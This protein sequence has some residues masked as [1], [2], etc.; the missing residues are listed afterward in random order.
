MIIKN[1]N[2]KIKEKALNIPTATLVWLI[3]LIGIYVIMQIVSDQKRLDFLFN[4]SFIPNIYSNFSSPKFYHFYSP[5]TYILIHG[6]LTHLIVNISMLAAFGS[7]IEKKFGIFNFLF[8]F[9][10]SSLI[11]I[12]THYLFFQ[13]SYSPVIGASGGICG[14]FSF[15]LIMRL[16]Y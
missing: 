7:I 8:I 12:F 9:L 10:F 16:I 6:N 1:E 4:Y 11:A 15:F 2:T 13:N 3:C 14:L 5:L